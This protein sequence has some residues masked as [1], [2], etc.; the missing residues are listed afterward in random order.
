ML[1]TGVLVGMLVLLVIGTPVFIFLGLPAAVAMMLGTTLPW[2][3][4]AS[5]VMEALR[6]DVLITIPMFLLVGEALA[7]SRAMD[8]LIGAFNALVG[9]IRG[10][11][12]LV[13]VLVA[14]FFAGISGST[15]AETAILARAL[16]VPLQQAGYPRQ[17]TAGLIASSATMGILIPPSIPMLLFASITAVPVS[18]LF[19]AGLLPGV[20]VGL[21]LAI[22]AIVIARRKGYGQA[23]KAGS[24]KQR[25]TAIV[26]ALPVLM[27][28]AFIVFALYSGFSTAT[29]TG[30][31][32]ATASLLIARLVYRE[33]TLRS[34]T[35]MLLRTAKVSS[36]VI[37]M[38]ATANLLGWLITY[39][40]VPQVITKFIVDAG[41]TPLMFLLAVNVLLFILGIPLDPPPIIFM[42]LPI[43]FPVLAG[44]NINPVHFA[45]VMVVNMQIAQISPPMGGALFALGTVGKVPL[46]EVYRGVLPFMGFLIMALL[47]LTYWPAASLQ[48]LR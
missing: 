38:S 45:V 43:L 32:A 8:D 21:I 9:H 31:I 23:G 14:M 20:L 2:E 34:L 44:L 24:L 35:R 12:A 1:I 25:G 17:Y 13:V 5:R 4:V 46:H 30:A 33:L 37:V 41:F 29:E 28:P 47:I 15:T 6:S 10:G 22:A 19:L 36:A 42:T 18:Q 27:I 11:L 26:R 40:R 7:G 48:L 39:E 3:A 16:V